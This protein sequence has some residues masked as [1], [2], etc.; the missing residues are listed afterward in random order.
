MRAVLFFFVVVMTLVYQK[1]EAHSK[2]ANLQFLFTVTKTVRTFVDF[3]TNVVLT[4]D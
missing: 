1:T 2:I 4:L 3:R